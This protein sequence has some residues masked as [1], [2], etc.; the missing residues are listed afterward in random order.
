MKAVIIEDEERS[1]IVLENLL[2]TY[3]PEVEVVA[4]A[5]SVA[6]GIEAI[7]TCQ[8]DLVFLDVQI[9]GGTGFDVLDSM[10]LSSISDLYNSV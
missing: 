5:D 6:A 8:P 2:S 10:K 4:K 1:R 9:N 3:C 7:Q